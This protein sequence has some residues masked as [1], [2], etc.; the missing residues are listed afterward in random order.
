[1]PQYWVSHQQVRDL[2]LQQ[3]AVRLLRTITIQI[4]GDLVVPNQ[5]RRGHRTPRK[6]VQLHLSVQKQEEIIRR[7]SPEGYGK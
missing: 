5:A 3:L 4:Q 1:M 7:K 6:S 2:H